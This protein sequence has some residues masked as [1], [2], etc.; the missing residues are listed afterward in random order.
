M[1]NIKEIPLNDRPRERLKLVGASS[2]STIELFAVVLSSGTRNVSVME[3]ANNLIRNYPSLNK[4]TE[5]SINELKKIPGIGDAKAVLLLA[6]IELGKRIN[7]PINY[8]NTI[9]SSLDAYGYLKDDMQ[10]LSNE[11]FICI[12][13]NCKSQVLLKKVI[14]VGGVS[15]TSVDAREVLKW[16][17]KESAY[18][19]ILSHNHPSGDA[20]PSKQDLDVTKKIIEASKTVGIVVCDHIII[21]KN[22][23]YSFMEHGII[24]KYE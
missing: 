7:Q 4:L 9:T 16:G 23:Y 24:K 17:L 11:V 20:A 2:L 6:C 5:V 21:G 12:Y 19:I 3:I 15:S 1:Y 22:C 8:T 10:N 13:L 14:G 18:G